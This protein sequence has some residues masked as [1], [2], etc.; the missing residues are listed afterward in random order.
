MEHKGYYSIASG[1]WVSHAEV[2]HAENAVDALRLESRAA[3]IR[4]K[5]YEA[6][7]D[8]A[9]ARGN[10]TEARRILAAGR[11]SERGPGTA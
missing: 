5:D 11:Y 7:A 6:R 4:R 3:I 10:F 2:V 8:E 1:K 9:A